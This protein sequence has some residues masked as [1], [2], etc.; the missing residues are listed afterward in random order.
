MEA[1]WN[2]VKDGRLTLWCSVT[3]VKPFTIDYKKTTLYIW[4]KDKTF[5]FS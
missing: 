2:S 5:Q 1:V 3:E 4:V